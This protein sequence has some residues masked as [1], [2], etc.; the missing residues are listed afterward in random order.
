MFASCS[1][2][3]RTEEAS[4]SDFCEESACFCYGAMLLASERS[5]GHVTSSYVS[6]SN[7][8]VREQPFELMGNWLHGI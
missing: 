3:T 4:L 6:R 5:V 1:F 7:G 8:N 2:V